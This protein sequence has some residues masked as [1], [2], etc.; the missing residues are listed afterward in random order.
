MDDEESRS[1]LFRSSCSRH[2]LEIASGHYGRLLTAS[3]PT[4]TAPL[5]STWLTSTLP[6]LP[7]FLSLPASSRQPFPTSHYLAGSSCGMR[8]TPVASPSARSPLTSTCTDRQVH[9]RHTDTTERSHRGAR[10]GIQRRTVRRRWWYP[11]A[12]PQ[13]SATRTAVSDVSAILISSENYENGAA[14]AFLRSSRL[15]YR[16]PSPSRVGHG[17]PNASQMSLPLRSPGYSKS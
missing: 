4:S 2:S 13:A 1:R 17:R 14:S 9:T 6:P 16:N 10:R 11:K 3:P 5:A 12:R 15:E 7:P 8:Y